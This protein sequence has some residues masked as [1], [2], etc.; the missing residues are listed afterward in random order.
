M[1]TLLQRW[2]KWLLLA[3]AWGVLAVA[4]VWGKTWLHDASSQWLAFA[5]LIGLSSFAMAAFQGQRAEKV[6]AGKRLKLATEASGVAIWEFDLV[7]KRYFW[8]AMMFTL[9]GLDP[10]AV[11]PRNDEW[12]KL[13]SNAD[14]K[15]M[16]NATRATIQHDQPFDMIFQVQRKDGSVRFMRNRAALYADDHGVPRRLI[17]STE[18]VTERKR[19]EAELRVAAAAFESHESMMVTNAELEIL[20]VNHAFCALFGYAPAEAVGHKPRLLKSG[21]QNNEFYGMMWAE[22]QAHHAWHGEI[23]NCKKDGEEFPCW[24][25]ITA[26]CDDDGVITHYVATHTDITLRKAAEDDVKRLA[27]YDPLTNLPN[28]RLLADR[29]Q[30]AL[31]KARRDRTPLALLYVDLDKFKPINDRYGHAAGDVLLQAVGLRLRACVRESDTVARVGGDEFVVLLTTLAAPEHAVAVAGKIHTSLRR[32]FM[33]PGGLEVTISSSTGV[34]IYPEHGSNEAELSR[35][36]DMAM[37]SAKAAGRDR[38]W[39]YTPDSV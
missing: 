11:G 39:V 12:Q 17:G 7:T 2:R 28:R 20:R 13:L 15:R 29:L 23:W 36:A 16:R 6:I 32:S 22:L 3:L 14:L 21:R 34:A 25:S 4:W 10:L 5:L 33:L 9:F 27:F 18:D 35:H 8:D 1:K 37:Y 38:Y 30:Q 26:V 19:Q 24:L 31:V